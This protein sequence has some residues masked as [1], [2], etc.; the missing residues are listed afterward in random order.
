MEAGMEAEV[1]AAPGVEDPEQG[2]N[3]PLIC[4]TRG[5]LLLLVE[6]GSCTAERASAAPQ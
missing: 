4:M 6:E 3:A 5:L 2:G 1:G